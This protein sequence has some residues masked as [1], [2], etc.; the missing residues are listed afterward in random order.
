MLA[1]QLPLCDALDLKGAGGIH[2]PT[3]GKALIEV[4]LS[5]ASEGG[6]S[7][8]LRVADRW[9][10]VG[11]NPQHSESLSAWQVPDPPLGAN[12]Y[13]KMKNPTSDR[14]VQHALVMETAGERRRRKLAELCEIHGREYVAA[15][16]NVHPLSLDQVIK[17]VLLPVK[18]DGTRSP[19]HL[20][21]TAA[22]AIERAF[23]LPEGWFD[24]PDATEGFSAAALDIA[25]AFDLMSLAEKR[26]LQLLIAAALEPMTEDH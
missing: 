13:V 20:G 21:D 26:R 11:H 1:R 22:R 17:G 18:R 15:R 12:R 9:C 23:D 3:P 6:E 25:R 14:D 7:F 8:S 19:R 24:S 5:H 2:V 4:G 16:S 10:Y